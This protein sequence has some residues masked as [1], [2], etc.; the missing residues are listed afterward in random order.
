MLKISVFIFLIA[1][2]FCSFARIDF[3]QLKKI[4]SVELVAEEG[5]VTAGEAFLVYL[6]V[7]LMNGSVLH[8]NLNKR[9]G[10]D[11]FNLT[12]IGA[13]RKLTSPKKK[14][15]TIKIV[16]GFQPLVSD[17][18]PQIYENSELNLVAHHGLF[19]NPFVR[20]QIRLTQ[21]PEI[22]SELL[23]PVRFSDNYTENL[24]GKDGT[25][26]LHGK[27]GSS[28]GART[29]DIRVNGRPGYFGTNGKDGDEG[30]SGKNAPDIDLF[31][32]VINHPTLNRELIKLEISSANGG[33]KIRYLEKSGRITINAFGGNGGDGGRGGNG[34]NGGNG[35]GGQVCVNVNNQIIPGEGGHGGSGGIGGNGGYGGNAGFGGNGGN[36]TIFIEQEALFFKSHIIIK[37]DGGL[38]GIPGDNGFGGT[39]GKG[40]PG[41]KSH[42]HDGWEGDNGLPG[43]YGTNG[44]NGSVNYIVWN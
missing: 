19:D 26:G 25:S 20:V 18:K 1:F 11:D 36:V 4:K 12:V 35:E 38:A 8:S 3:K 22:Y 32:S 24:F 33:D 14:N 2:S 44:I 31:V 21:Y 15:V 23:V 30:V 27:Q 28:S 16:H 5:T 7:E 6:K 42:G 9:I 17:N 29:C 39:A 13:E 41:G 43:Y 34:G 40:A 10:F 37:N